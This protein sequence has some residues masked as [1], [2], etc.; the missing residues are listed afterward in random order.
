MLHVAGPN[1]R[2]RCDGRG[3][4]TWKSDGALGDDPLLEV[5]KS[6]GLHL[7]VTE[8]VPVSGAASVCRCRGST[9]KRCMICGRRWQS[10]SQVTA[11]RK[12]PNETDVSGDD[13]TAVRYSVWLFFFCLRR[14]H[15]RLNWLW[16]IVINV[17]RYLKCVCLCVCSVLLEK[18]MHLFHLKL[19]ESGV[20][21]CTAWL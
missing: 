10:I 1:F 17:A 9:L 16:L 19:C 7:V 4:R 5:L 21:T 13:S 18:C 8:V 3:V 12:R 20:Y 11:R 2:Y 6:G 15:L 14:S